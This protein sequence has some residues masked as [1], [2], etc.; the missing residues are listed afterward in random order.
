MVVG[1]LPEGRRSEF[2]FQNNVLQYINRLCVPK[3][4]K[5]KNKV[6]EEARS[7]RYSVHPGGTK[8]YWD[9]KEVYW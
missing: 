4:V 6:I 5:L 3:I 9:L 2:S 7:T 1:E 8:M